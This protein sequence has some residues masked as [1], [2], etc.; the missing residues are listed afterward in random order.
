ML[1][2]LLLRGP[3]CC[4]TT[5]SP[6]RVQAKRTRNNRNCLKQAF[7]DLHNGA[8]VEQWKT[9]G[10]GKKKYCQLFSPR[11]CKIANH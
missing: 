2:L 4:K 9:V 11:R 5:F 8:V 3:S 10:H 1:S 6:D 7:W